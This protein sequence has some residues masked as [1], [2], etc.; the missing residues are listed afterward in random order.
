MGRN[1]RSARRR[2]SGMTSEHLRPLLD[3]VRSMR[4]PVPIGRESDQS[5]RASHCRPRGEMWADDSPRQTRWFRCEGSCRVW[6]HVRW[7]DRWVP[8]SR[9]PHYLTSTPY[10][11]G[12]CGNA[13]PMFCKDSAS[14]KPQDHRDTCRRRQCAWPH[15]PD[16]NVDGLET[17]V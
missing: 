9:R 15:F 4:S 8:V 7:P 13:T 5:P 17:C 11:C 14:L 12:R 3:E 6:L 1:L 10:P 16:G 2:P